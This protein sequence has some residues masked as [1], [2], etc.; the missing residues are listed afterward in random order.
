MMNDML[1]YHCKR[2]ECQNNV[3]FL[4][5]TIAL[6]SRRR[7][8]LQ[9]NFVV[10]G[11]TKLSSK[12]Y[13]LLFEAK[14]GCSSLITKRLT[15]SSSFDVWKTNVWVCSISN[16]VNLVKVLL[17]LK[18]DHLKPKV[19]CSS[20]ITN[21]WTRSSLFNVGKLMFEFDRCSI[22]RSQK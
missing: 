12:F 11:R 3:T 7:K 13:V 8:V 16:L 21:R 2:L 14:N 22:V 17:N 20:S 15:R 18:F 10:M 1:T 9:S 19:G 4:G 5:C 6:R